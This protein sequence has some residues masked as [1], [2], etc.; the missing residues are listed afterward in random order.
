M[1]A[2]LEILRFSLLRVYLKI[3]ALLTFLS[4]DSCNLNSTDSQFT[5][6]RRYTSELLLFVDILQLRFFPL[7]NK[8]VSSKQLGKYKNKNIYN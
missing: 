6:T 5:F 3:S 2:D 7:L 8:T 1:I 4:A